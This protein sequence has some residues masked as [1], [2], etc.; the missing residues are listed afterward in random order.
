MVLRA[1]QCHQLFQLRVLLVSCFE[2]R[3]KVSRLV[4]S[5]K[6]PELNGLAKLLPFQLPPQLAILT[7]HRIFISNRALQLQLQP[8]NFIKQSLNKLSLAFDDLLKQTIAR[9]TAWPEFLELLN[10][11]IHL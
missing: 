11:K 10:Y 1:V 7:N 8:V 9:R 3:L 6:L 2:K 5:V 4:L